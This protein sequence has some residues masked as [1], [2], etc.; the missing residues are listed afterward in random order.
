MR[1]SVTRQMPHN[2]RCIC[3]LWLVQCMWLYTN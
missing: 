2:Y 3:W 1:V